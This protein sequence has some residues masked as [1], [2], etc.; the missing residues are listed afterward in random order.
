[1][2]RMHNEEMS[3]KKVKHECNTKRV[4]KEKHGK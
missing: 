1:M 2:K 3:H 4:K